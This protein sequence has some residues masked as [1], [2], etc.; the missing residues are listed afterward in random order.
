MANEQGISEGEPGGSALDLAP[1]AEPEPLDA[2]ACYEALKT[3]DPRF[4]GVFFVGV[5]STKIYCRPICHARLPK[6]E[7][8]TFFRTAAEAESAGYRPCLQCRPEAAPGRSTSDAVSSLAA[9]AARIIES[10]CATIGNLDD[11]AARLGYTSRH[12][13][14]AFESAYQVTPHQYLQTCR[15]LLAKNLISETTVPVSEV[16]LACGFKSVRRFNDAFKQQYRLQPTDLRKR[17]HDSS[18]EGKTSIAVQLGYRPPY[19][20]REQL[21]FLSLRAIP[22]VESV[23]VP[24]RERDGAYVRAVRVRRRDGTFAEGAIRVIRHPKKDALVLEAQDS[25]APVLPLVIARVKDLFDLRCDVDAVFDRLAPMSSIDASLPIRGL[26]VPGCFDPFEMSVRAV[27]GQQ[28]TVKAASTLAGRI[29]HELGH[30]VGSSFPEVTCVF[31]TAEEIEAHGARLGDELGRLGVIRTRQRTI[32]ALAHAF[33][34]GDV[35]CGYGCDPLRQI[36]NLRA[37]PGIGDWTAQY[38]AMRALRYAD[39]F[40]ATD[41]G[42]KKAL[43]PRSERE[44]RELAR[45]WSPWR[46]YAT[47]SLWNLEAA[48]A[49]PARK[50]A[51]GG[52]ANAAA[53]PVEE[54]EVRRSADEQGA[55]AYRTAHRKENTT[56]TGTT[57][58]AQTERKPHERH[59]GHDAATEKGTSRAKRERYAVEYESPL[60]KLTLAATPQGVSGLWIEGQKYFGGTKNALLAGATFVD[61]TDLPK[62]DAKVD[63]GRAAAL[64]ALS[65]AMTWLDRYFAGEKPQPNDLPLAP[66]GSAFRQAVW[67]QL[68]L[69]PYGATTTYGAIART[70][71]EESGKEHVSAQAVGGAVGHNPISIIIPC[72]RVVGASGSLTGYAG[73]V[74][75]KLALLKHEGAPLDGLF[76][77]TKGTAL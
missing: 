10:E 14:R 56:M 37:L 43:A 77:P 47:L 1:D 13:R 65:Q 27:L 67:R 6:F 70:L 46:A 30:P 73:G 74:D 57:S 52:K 35:D 66:E 51:H 40:P 38:I 29:A 17:A 21:E 44:V 25:L 53:A 16:A 23:Q 55:L 24:Q 42:V 19:A 60:G 76:V 48:Q 12:L 31:P 32:A 72:H 3:H 18:G 7:N 4:D 2:R 50:R 22:G 68:C 15:L 75:R 63:D 39:A 45:T 5:S 8:C 62:S 34:S 41:L 36:E 61:R 28:I 49:T 20:W 58:Q 64:S 59:A 71:A 26:R 11:V 33:A 54:A 69:I 9:R